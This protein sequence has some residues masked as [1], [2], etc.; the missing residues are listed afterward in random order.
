MFFKRGFE[1]LDKT[2]LET[3]IILLKASI[4][5]EIL[6][7]DKEYKFLAS[8]YF[9]INN[10]FKDSSSED[11]LQ[12]YTDFLNS[13][14]RKEYKLYKKKVKYRKENDKNEIKLIL[15]NTS[16][17]SYD[18]FYALDA[19]RVYD[20][21]MDNKTCEIGPYGDLLVDGF[22]FYNNGNVYNEQNVKSE[23]LE[24]LDEYY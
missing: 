5:L 23:E 4:V 1:G 24:G 15:H 9:N 16:S 22:S 18:D 11:M 12:T 6:S 2:F 8:K 13:L 17:Y 19:L 3:R 7:G 20:A 14:K 21:K 10:L